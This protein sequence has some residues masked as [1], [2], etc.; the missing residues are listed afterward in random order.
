MIG[1]APVDSPDRLASDSASDPAAPEGPGP[2]D[3]A[4]AMA[5]NASFEIRSAFIDRLPRVTID[6]NG[7]PRERIV[8]EGDQLLTRAQIL[9]VLASADTAEAAPA[10]GELRV[11]VDARGRPTFWPPDKRQLTYW[12]DPA[13]FR[14]REEYDFVRARIAEAGADWEAACPECGVDFSETATPAGASF[15]V[16][17]LRGRQPFIATAFFPNDPPWRRFLYIGSEFLTTGFSQTGIIRHELGH[18]LGYRHEHIVGVAGCYREDNR[19]R[20]LTDYDPQSVMHYFC[21]G[22]GTRDL[23]LSET[24]IAGHRRLYEWREQ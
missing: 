8:W 15:K 16:Q 1:C 10:S 3:F 22:G 20:S 7:T 13:S 6:D 21:G 11:M 4:A 17:F 12:V 23:N 18:V 14:N 2:A 24:D 5:P 19:W 9:A